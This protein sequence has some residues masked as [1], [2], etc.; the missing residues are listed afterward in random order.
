MEHQI[1]YGRGGY[2]VNPPQMDEATGEYVGEPQVFQRHT[3]SEQTYTEAPN[4]DVYH[5]PETPAPLSN[6]ASD[7]EVLSFWK[8][9][10]PLSES[11]VA[12][13]QE[14]Y[15]RDGDEN[16]ANLLM[17]R[18]TGETA[19]LTPEQI[20]ELGLD[21]DAEEVQ[22]V[23]DISDEDF[24]ERAEAVIDFEPEVSEQSQQMVLN[25]DL[26]SHGNAGVVVQQM[27]MQ[28]VSGQMTTEDAMQKALDSG[29]NPVQ[30]YNAYHAL[31]TQTN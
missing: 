4:S 9:D 20:Y 31:Y 26:S 25:A 28:V 22:E 17:W 29:I 19:H 11:Q 15:V 1:N 23:D 18:L 8:G 2:T 30:L 7:A 3:G 12:A 13:I 5:A 6:N 24:N 10:Q 27:A 21:G 16:L 14:A